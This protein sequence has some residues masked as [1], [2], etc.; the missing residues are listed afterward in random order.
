MDGPEAR[1]CH[2]P[3]ATLRR[4]ENRKAHAVTSRRMIAQLAAF[5]DSFIVLRVTLPLH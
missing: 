3:T 2:E 5:Q 4:A 1:C